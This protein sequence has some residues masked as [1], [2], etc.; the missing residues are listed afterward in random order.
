ML[1]GKSGGKNYMYDKIWRKIICSLRGVKRHLTGK[2]DIGGVKE[3]LAGK[4]YVVCGVT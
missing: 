2:L 4:L 1:R 3:D